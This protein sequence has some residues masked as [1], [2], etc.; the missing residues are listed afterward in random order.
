MKNTLSQEFAALRT[1]RG[2]TLLEI[3]EKCNL[4]ESTVWKIEN[5]RSVRWETVHLVLSVAL[6]C[7]PGTE[8]Y[9][10]MQALW[11]IARQEMAESQTTTFATPK[12]KPHTAAAIR[13]LRKIITPL[14]ETKTAKVV[15]AAL[16]AAK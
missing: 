11:V 1:R 7:P 12:I 14:D 16:R 5:N 10:A 3:A 2:M 9:H 13:K 4:A 8:R 6:G 15:A